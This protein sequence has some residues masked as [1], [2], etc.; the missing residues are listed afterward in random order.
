MDNTP[1]GPQDGVPRRRFLKAACA[2][3]AA[4]GLAGCTTFGSE[5]DAN[6]IQWY[7]DS[8]AREA[9]DAIQQGL[10]DVG[11][12]QDISL[13]VIAGPSDTAQRQQL[14]Q[15][16]LDA[17]L[18]EPTLMM[19]DS[20]WTVP[21]A[22]R[23]QLLNLTQ[24]ETVPD[25]LVK[26]IENKYVE[27]S[28]QTA[29][30]PQ[31]GDLYAM[32][33]YPDFG[34]MQYRKDWAEQ[35]GYD[36]DGENWATEGI[37]WKKFS[38]VTKQ[39]M[40]QNDLPYGFTFQANVYE[41]LSCCDFNEF[42]TS[43]GGAYFGGRENL[44]GPVGDRPVTLNEQPVIDSIRMIRTFMR[45]QQDP[46]SLPGYAGN[47]APRAVLS[48]IEDSSLAPFT[49]GNAFAHRN[50]PYAIATNGE[51]FGEKLGVMPIPY[52][53]TEQQSEYANIGGPTAALG[54][55]HVAINPNTNKLEQ[56]VQVLEAMTKRSFKLMLF[57]T[58]GWL[59]PDM[60]V[61]DSQAARDVPIVGN[62]IE[63]LQAASKNAIPRPVT[64][65]WPQESTKIAQLVNATY[66][67]G[68]APQE[69]MQTLQSQIEEIETYNA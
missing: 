36:P 46:H 2:S 59:P 25:G 3:G 54:G 12:S 7:A 13:E 17:N 27:A 9:R 43:W 39:A 20:G 31:T 33:L 26:L 49:N 34:T 66:S 52:A 32:P 50:W 15:R 55:W 4:V 23:D 1:N 45:G 30:N 58:I 44:F 22:I 40:E 21:F 60:Q 51:K 62:Y 61:L 56:A 35:A 64:T 65:V 10:W 47:I 69:T 5:A 48:W 16:W 63:P 18:S 42:M 19:V 24:N 68:G 53:V 28:V 41:G 38:R 57:E 67:G 6:T 14:L 37:T 8:D 11:L 29:K